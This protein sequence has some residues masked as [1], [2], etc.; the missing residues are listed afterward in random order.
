MDLT[1]DDYTLLTKRM[2][3]I[4]EENHKKMDNINTDFFKELID[5]LQVL[6]KALKEVHIIVNTPYLESS[7]AGQ[8]REWPSEYPL[9][10]KAQNVEIIPK[11]LY[12]G[13]SD[14]NNKV[15]GITYIELNMFNL[16]LFIVHNVL[17]QAK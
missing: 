2:V 11:E 4:A 13:N 15:H 14:L 3:E 1:D 9:S 6:C 8:S 12:L 10:K 5:L 17:N 16:S 7:E